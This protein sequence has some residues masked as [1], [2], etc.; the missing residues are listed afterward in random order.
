M[1]EF[2]NNRQAV[3]NAICLLIVVGIILIVIVRAFKGYDD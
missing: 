1:I 2:L 3:E